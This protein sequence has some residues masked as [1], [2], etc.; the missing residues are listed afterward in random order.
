MQIFKAGNIDREKLP[1][2]VDNL[3]PRDQVS[4]NEATA[5]IW[6]Q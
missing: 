4:D 6:P 3:S 2:D 5:S 1:K